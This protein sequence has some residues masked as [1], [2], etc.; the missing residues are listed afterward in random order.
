VLPLTLALAAFAPAGI[1]WACKRS[2]P[3]NA[4]GPVILAY[5]V[6][7]LW[8][9]GVELAGIS[10]DSGPVETFAGVA[11]M[12]A[13]ALL[14]VGSDFRAWI[15]LAP[16][17]LKGFG[18][19]LLSV[20]IVVP[21]GTLLFPMEE[22]WKVGGML[23]GV[24]TGGTANL[25][26]LATALD[27]PPETLLLVHGS[28]VVVGGA[29]L[30][31]L[32]SVGP[33][34]YGRC[35]PA[36]EGAKSTGEE[37]AEERPPPSRL[38][39]VQ[40]VGIGLGILAVGLGIAAAADAMSERALLEPVAIL[41]ITTLAIAASFMPK[42]RAQPGTAP[43]GDY[44][45]L[46]FSLGVGTLA[47]A[48]VMQDADLRVVAF[49]GF[50]VLGSAA[51]HL[52]LCRLAGVDRDTAIITSVAGL[53][54]PPFVPPVAKALG[55]REVI[56]SGITTGILGLALGNYMGMGMAWLLRALL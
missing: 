55:N 25:M 41:A 22:G 14:L 27:V 4:L 34:L 47:R 45:L 18:L 35:L 50:V 28:D 30:L 16:V 42:A 29:Y 49:T 21:L 39:L 5:L 9:N 10:M 20:A 13:I 53:Y 26:A 51:L 52:L 2:K 8:G 54:G 1:L 3:L 48:S 46:V 43:A 32:L 36:F 31:F 23:V 12:L 19:A 33:R 56:V 7:I 11:V 15:R 37:S 24:Y 40:G 6:G 44:L 38:Q 17:T